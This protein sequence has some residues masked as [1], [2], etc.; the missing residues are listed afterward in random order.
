MPILGGFIQ[1]RPNPWENPGSTH[2]QLALRDNHQGSVHR[3]RRPSFQI[4]GHVGPAINGERFDVA[5]LRIL[6]LQE[7]R[8]KANLIF[9]WVGVIFRLIED[10]AGNIELL[11]FV[12]FEEF[13]D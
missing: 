6:G 10:D 12:F 1:E 9:R 13:G 8:E 4:I 5:G 2:R 3:R 7:R 11:A